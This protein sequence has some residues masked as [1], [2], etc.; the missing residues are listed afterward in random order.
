[1]QENNAEIIA[2]IEGEKR[3]LNIHG[4]RSGLIALALSIAEKVAKETNISYEE[5]CRMLKIGWDMENENP[6]KK[7]YTMFGD[8]FNK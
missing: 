5:F 2:K 8:L 7:F 1:M 6:E 3:T 4:A